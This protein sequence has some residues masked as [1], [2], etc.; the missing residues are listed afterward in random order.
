MI[1][2]SLNHKS[3]LQMDY[4]N[5]SHP[6]FLGG[7][8]AVEAALQ[9]QWGSKVSTSNITK[10]KV[11]AQYLCTSLSFLKSPFH[12]VMV[13]LVTVR[14][15]QAMNFN[16]TYFTTFSHC[17]GSSVLEPILISCYSSR[18]WDVLLLQC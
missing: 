7:S 11:S 6:G 12:V 3:C 15:L 2:M 8:K 16:K 13:V 5:T 9:Q 10:A 14:T 4:I 1:N 17:R 18:N